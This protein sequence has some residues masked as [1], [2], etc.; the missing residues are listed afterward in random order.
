MIVFDEY[1]NH[2]TWRDH[3]YKAFQ[4]FVGRSGFKY[5]YLAYAHHQVA[6]ILTEVP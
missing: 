1:F 3:E 6:L 4:E 5:D 2:P